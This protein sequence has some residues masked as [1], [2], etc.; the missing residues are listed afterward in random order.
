MASRASRR[1]AASGV[2]RTPEWQGRETFVRSYDPR[3]LKTSRSVRA[4]NCLGRFKRL[5]DRDVRMTDGED[6]ELQVVQAQ[7][8][9][10][11]ERHYE[12]RLKGAVGSDGVAL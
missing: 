4:C 9:H 5:E 1:Q 7:G 10:R 6:Q 12:R 3:A 11:V 2:S 8:A